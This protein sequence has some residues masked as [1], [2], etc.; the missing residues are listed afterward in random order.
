[1]TAED[2]RP[3]PPVAHVQRDCPDREWCLCV[4]FCYQAYLL[5]PECRDNPTCAVPSASELRSECL[6]RILDWERAEPGSRREQ[7]AAEAFT[8]AFSELDA[9]LTDGTSALPPEWE[10]SALSRRRYR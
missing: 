9:C 7:E 8:R 1:M 10:P 6:D 2:G 4:G 3:I 5:R